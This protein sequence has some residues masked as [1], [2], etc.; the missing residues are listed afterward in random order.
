MIGALIYIRGHY[1]IQ[2]VYVE[3]NVHYT[4]EEI[5]DIVMNG[6]LGDNSLYLSMKYKNKGV[7]NIPFVDVMDVSILSPDTIKITVYEKALAGYVTYL[8]TLF[9]FDKDGYVVESSSVKTV[10]VPQ[11]TGLHFD[12]VILGEPLPV[13]NKE[14]FNTILDITKLLNKYELMADKIYFQSSN[15]ITIYFGDVKVALGDEPQWLEDKVMRLPTF[16][17]E[18]VGKSGTLQMEAYEEANGKYSFKPDT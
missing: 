13:E 17:K 15:K 9:Y 7:D 12:R 5:R 18:L 4:E 14:I 1:K 3:G 11:I 8:D 10:G 2:N 6:A 16:L